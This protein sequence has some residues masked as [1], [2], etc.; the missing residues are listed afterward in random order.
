MAVCITPFRSMST[1]V[2]LVS[3]AMEFNS[4]RWSHRSIL[5]TALQILVKNGILP[6]H[7]RYPLVGNRLG[8]GFAWQLYVENFYDLY[9]MYFIALQ[10]QARLGKVSI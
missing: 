10:Y 2:W 8:T 1:M 5:P 4:K 7:S 9:D 6:N 3:F